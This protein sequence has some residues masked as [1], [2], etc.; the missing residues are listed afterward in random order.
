VLYNL[1]LVG[2]FFLDGM[3]NAAEQLCGRTFGARDREGFMRA[4]TLIVRW[5]FAFGVGASVLFF[6]FGGTFV[7]QMTTSPEVRRAAAEYLPLMALAPVCGVLAF[8]YDGIY[9]GATWVR[10]MRNLM[11]LSFVIYLAVWWIAQPLGNTGLWIA[12]L[13]WFASR[14]L[15]QM[16]RYPALARASFR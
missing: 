16:A 8:S 12:L 3:A 9:I 5:A 10:D 15:L 4:V 1:M 7:A 13:C 11:V 14:G 2:S 6:V